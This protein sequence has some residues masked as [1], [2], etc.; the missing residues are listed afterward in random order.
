MSQQTTAAQ[1]TTVSQQPAVER[2]PAWPPALTPYIMVSDARRAIA[3]PIRG[4]VSASSQRMS[5]GSTKCQV[6]RRTWVRRIAPS[7]SKASTAAC[8]VPPVRWAIAQLAP[9]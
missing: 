8:V 9:P 3:W 2:E 5:A 6:G 4:P 1:Q 7:A